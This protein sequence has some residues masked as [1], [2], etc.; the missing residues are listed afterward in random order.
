[1]NA[2]LTNKTKRLHREDFNCHSSSSFTHRAL[3]LFKH[4]YL[5]NKVYQQYCTLL[6]RNLNNVTS[7]EDLPFLPISFFKTH[8][9]VTGIFEP[10][11]VFLSSG[12]TSKEASKHYIKDLTLYEYSFTQSFCHFYGAIEQYTFLALLPNYQENPHSSLIYMVDRLMQLSK[13]PY[14]GYFLN[15]YKQLFEQLIF[16]KNKKSKVILFGV[17]Y[18][19]LD[20]VTHYQLHFPELIV[21][22]TGGMKGRRKEM[23]KEEL[24]SILS[25]A[26]GVSSIHS[27]Y[28]MCELLSQAYSKGNNVFYTPPHM[29]LLLRDEHNPLLHNHIIST[30][31][32]NVIDLANEHSC[33]FI[34][35][36]DLGRCHSDGGME[37]LGRMDS[38][39]IRGCN[40]LIM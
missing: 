35:T 28:G 31:L 3:Q 7:I 33:A 16:L 2:K 5:N 37:I 19:L 22:E 40:L 29:K 12:T 15:N 25:E 18:A 17:S 38:A 11:S 21:F 4:Q 14:N 36:D 39:E 34:A 27:E 20:F 26:F 30:G 6:H 24:H 23:I 1:M 10:Q 8:K 32:I 13:S 9:V